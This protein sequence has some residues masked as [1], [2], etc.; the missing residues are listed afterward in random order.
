M[1]D[2]AQWIAAIATVV[3][4]VV[5]AI[6]IYQN[7][8]VIHLYEKNDENQFRP[9][10][11]LY[12]A[13]DGN[14]I[15]L[16]IINEGNRTAE[17]VK[18]SFDKQIRYDGTPDIDFI[19]RIDELT[20]TTMDIGINVKWDLSLCLGRDL[21]KIRPHQVV[22]NVSYQSGT[23]KFSETTT[24]NFMSIGWA[25]AEDG[26]VTVLKRIEAKIGNK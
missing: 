11:S 16:R 1:T 21:E 12:L 7:Y 3:Y 4:T 8:K 25:R 19:T 22:A 2:E 20:S 23:K 6:V 13:N 9:I 17:K 26:I 18:V 5:T 24:I 14:L 10:V 15:L